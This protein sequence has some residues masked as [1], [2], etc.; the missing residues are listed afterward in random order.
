MSTKNLQDIE[1]A[2]I[3]T[4]VERFGGNV[5]KAAEALNI[6]RATMYRKLKKV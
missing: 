3:R 6:S 2:H 4:V 1:Y 5:S